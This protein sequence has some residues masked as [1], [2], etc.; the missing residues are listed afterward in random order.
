M[1]ASHQQRTKPHL[2]FKHNGTRCWVE[3]WDVRMAS[4]YTI[5]EVRCSTDEPQ[6]VFKIHSSEHD[7]WHEAVGHM[8]WMRDMGA[9]QPGVYTLTCNG[10]RHSFE[11]T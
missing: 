1:P 11:V 9:L 7:A 6:R 10:R 3:L 4:R 8:N 2:Q 5:I